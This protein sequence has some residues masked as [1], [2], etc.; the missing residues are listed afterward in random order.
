MKIYNF[1]FNYLSLPLLPNSPWTLRFLSLILRGKIFH[2][3]F[4]NYLQIC[5]NKKEN[6]KVIF[7]AEK[8]LFK[9][10]LSF[11]IFE[12]YLSSLRNLGRNNDCIK[13]SY[14][15]LKLY[16]YLDIGYWHLLH[17]YIAVGEVLKA[18]E[19][20]QRFN[21]SLINSNRF[22]NLCFGNKTIEKLLLYSK[23]DTGSDFFHL[24]FSDSGLIGQ[25]LLKIKL[26]NCKEKKS[27]FV[28][29]ISS[30]A[31]FS[32][33]LIALLNSIGIAKLLNIKQIFIIKTDLTTALCAKN[34]EIQ[35]INIRTIK[36][37]PSGNYISGNFFS[38]YK[39]LK[40]QN[41]EFSKTRTQYASSILSKFSLQNKNPKIELVI[42]VRS[43]DIF[44][45]RT[46]HKN[47][48]QPPL[49]FYIL[50][51]KDINP[52]SIT[53]VFEDY[54]NPVIILLISY[55][56]SIDCKLKLNK[57]NSLK[58]DVSC[59]LN[60]KAIIFGN[61]TFVPGILLGSKSIEKIYGFELKQKFKEFW[62][63]ERVENIF[64]VTD[65]IGLYRKS[66][67]NNNWR[68][69]NSQLKLMKKYSINNLKLNKF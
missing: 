5:I 69:S 45:S 24:F 17:S 30:H 16:P 56:N 55:I 47:Y 10:N 3:L 29:F 32:N 25:S 36:S 65:E 11:S 50:C 13:C 22:L 33:T 64:N 18:K 43:G 20:V 40:L 49:A 26:S 19:I 53:L 31:G 15:L 52:S 51:I 2:D 6:K 54:S 68:A 59:I 35:N 62:S 1:L 14:K 41:P 61:G 39:F 67:L 42:H 63:L 58:E 48:G 57:F 38:H 34:L 4:K 60:A 23:I 27:N 66:V 28:I 8:F 44:R 21:T 7:A 46:V 37:N 9:R 12:I